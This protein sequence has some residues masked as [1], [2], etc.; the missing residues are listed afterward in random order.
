MYMSKPLMSSKNPLEEFTH[1]IV[2]TNCGLVAERS[3][4]R[5]TSSVAFP[6]IICNINS[7]TTQMEG[8]TKARHFYN[9]AF[10]SG[11]W[12]PVTDEQKSGSGVG[13]LKLY[14]RT[15]GHD[16]IVLFSPANA[17][18]A[19]ARATRADIASSLSDAKQYQVHRAFLFVYTTIR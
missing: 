17:R 4:I 11:P 12:G 18:P 3:V 7:P 14:P 5:H 2:Y 16:L 1:E 9:R 19:V 13:S 8:K 15:T 10:T 6:K